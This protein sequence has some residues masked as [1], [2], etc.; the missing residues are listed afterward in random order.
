MQLEK[1]LFSHWKIHLQG[2]QGINSYFF[3]WNKNVKLCKT[4]FMKC[5]GTSKWALSGKSFQGENLAQ[6]S[7]DLAEEPQN[8]ELRQLQSRVSSGTAWWENGCGPHCP[9]GDWTTRSENMLWNYYMGFLITEI[10][11]MYLMCMSRLKHSFF[12]LSLQSFFSP[13]QRDLGVLA[14]IR[15]KVSQHWQLPLP[16]LPLL[17]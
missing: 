8:C 5:K 14:G 11:L 2:K 12:P 13:A 1:F 6:S 4:I 3:G 10:Y 15:L 17:F 9:Q 16:S 7:K